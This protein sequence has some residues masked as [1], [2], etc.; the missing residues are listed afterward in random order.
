MAAA[1]R[2]LYPEAASLDGGRL[3]IGGCDA[4]ELAREFGTP[5]Y[6]VAEDDLRARAREFAGAMERHHPGPSA[7]A[8]ASKAFPATAVLR[9]FREEGLHADVASLGELHLARRAGYAGPEIVVHGNAKSIAELEA[10][11]AA[12]ATIVID[13]LDELDRLAGLAGPGAAQ[14]ILLRV[15][16][17][18]ETR[19]HASIATGHADSKFGLSLDDAPVAIERAG[20]AAGLH[21]AGLHIHLGSS[22]SIPSPTAARSPPSARSGSSRPTTSGAASASPTPRR[23]P[24]SISTRRSPPWSRPRTST[25]APATSR[26]RSSRAGPSSRRRA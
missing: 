23:R 20:A 12:G 13:N 19:T 16:P 8:F 1:T 3:V 15:N 24:R 26:S 5:A 9:V 21:L 17:S 22:S 7:V 11:A 25:S 14:R 18:V 4:A 2:S 10:A 6:V